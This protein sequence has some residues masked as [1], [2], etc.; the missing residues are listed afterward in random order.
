MT[1]ASSS[2]LLRSFPPVIARSSR[3]LVLG[4]MPGERSLQAGEYYAHPQNAFWRLMDDILGIPAALPYAQRLQRVTARG[5][6][7]WEVLASCERAGSLDTA[8]RNATPNDFE[9]L[10]KAYPRLVAVLFNG[11]KAE[12]LWRRHVRAGPAS[13]TVRTLPSSS[14]A[15]ARMSYDGKRQAWAEAIR[16]QGIPLKDAA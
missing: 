14:P 1:D 3:V 15:N 16:D 11:R 10:F 9:S 13:V 7:L 12:E 2:P 4:T 8:I 5:V 6:A